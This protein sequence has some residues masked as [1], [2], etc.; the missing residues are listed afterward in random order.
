MRFVP[1][2]VPRES[3]KHE[4]SVKFNSYDVPG[5]PFV[6]N[7]VDVTKVALVNT[8][9]NKTLLYPIFKTNSIDFNA[10]DSNLMTVKMT[11]PTGKQ[12]PINRSPNNSSRFNFQAA[13]IGNLSPGI[14]NN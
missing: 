8:E 5:S 12:V 11:S 1:S 3:G 9:Q 14:I 6:C 13:E 4:V 2:F 7:V 10:G